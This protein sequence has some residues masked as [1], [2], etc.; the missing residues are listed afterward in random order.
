MRRLVVGIL[1]L[2]SVL[3]VGACR[4]KHGAGGG[5]GG[6]GADPEETLNGSLI[7][8]PG[9]YTL[10]NPPTDNTITVSGSPSAPG[11]GTM[12]GGMVNVG[13]SFNAPGANIVGA[14]IRIGTTGP[15]NVV[16]IA[17]A[18]G[19]TSGSLAFPMGIPP[20]VCGDLADICHSITC[21]EFAVTAA[22]TISAAN[23]NQLA[24]VCG[25]CDEPTCQDLLDM[26]E[27]GTCDAS[28]FDCGDGTCIDASLA[29]N[30]ANDCSNASDEDPTTCGDPDN[31]CAA[32]NGCPDE[33][34]GSCGAA[35][36]CC[37]GGE[38]C[39][40]ATGGCGPAS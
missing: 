21:Y 14:G 27:E 17:G 4:G 26:C 11:A 1:G 36:C 35:C 16:P 2:A 15:V 9:S 38:A 6:G 19:N 3:A 29:C 8:P 31:C 32:T 37:G 22:G 39:T 30:R 33:T 24:L 28:Q 13:V 25:N 18:M 23:I 20:G 34:G 40:S 7:L 10:M 5:G 12:P